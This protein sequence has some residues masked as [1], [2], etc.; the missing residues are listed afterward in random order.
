MR[1]LF[2]ITGTSMIVGAVSPGAG[3]GDAAGI[4]SYLADVK[5]L[6]DIDGDGR[7]D[8]LTDG[9]LLCRYLFGLRGPSLSA[10]AIAPGA[11]RSTP[12]AIETR[13]ASL[14]P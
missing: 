6:L 11:T 7:A 14:S 5:P 4:A 2:G 12:A 13:I 9:I 8:A 3:R 10:G 1:Y